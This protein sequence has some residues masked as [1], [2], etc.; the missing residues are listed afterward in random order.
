MWH[1]QYMEEV[2]VDELRG[3]EAAME[4]FIKSHV[5]SGNMPLSKWKSNKK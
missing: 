4:T 5:M 2:D 3:D 1:E